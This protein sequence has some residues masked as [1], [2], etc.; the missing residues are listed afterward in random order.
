[1]KT[2][3]YILGFCTLSLSLYSQTG[4][5]IKGKIL[6]SLSKEP[7]YN[8][9]VWVEAGSSMIGTTTD[10]EGR[11]TLKPLSAGYYD[12]NVSY[13][14][15]KKYILDDVRVNNG[16]ITMLLD[17]FLSDNTTLGIIDV[18]GE[19]FT[20]KERLIKPEDPSVMTILASDLKTNVN[21]KSPLKMI[22]NSVPAIYQADDGQPL[23]FR[24]S[25]SD[26]VQYYVDGVKTRDG[27]LGIPSCAIGEINVYTGG[28]P[29]R[30]GDL[31]GGVVVIETKSFFEIY[32]QRK[33]H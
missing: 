31:T 14:G 22:A 23:Y 15:K 20:D 25:R 18:F 24:G 26:A 19:R 10:F 5:E 32:N 9:N 6:D 16:K 21:N 8:A 30:Y 4:G 7:L 11:F 28:V 2:T 33:N 27:N 1:M 29:A 13:I 3:L 12:L 17:I